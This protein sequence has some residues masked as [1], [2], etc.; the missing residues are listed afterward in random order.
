MPI[1]AII[2]GDR[3]PAGISLP[4]FPGGGAGLAQA[5]LYLATAQEQCRLHAFGRVQGEIRS[6]GSLR[7]PCIFETPPP[8]S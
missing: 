6:S 1:P 5:A 4:G 3:R 8:G 7:F 2:P